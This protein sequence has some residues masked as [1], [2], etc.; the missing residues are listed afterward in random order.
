VQNNT[1]LF[2]ESSQKKPTFAN[3]CK[4]A[5]FAAFEAKKQKKRLFI[6]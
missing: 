6:A 3:V 4:K 5:Y 2:L 1:I